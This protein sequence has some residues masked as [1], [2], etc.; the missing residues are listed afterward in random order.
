MKQRP[1]IVGITKVRNEEVIIQDTLD[2]FGQFCD[3][4]YVYDDLSDDDTFKIC[5][6][7]PKV[8]RTIKGLRWDQNRPKA[9]FQ[10]RQRVLEE[11]Q[12]TNP[13]W[14]LYFDADER[15]D[16]DFKEYNHYDAVIMKLFDF[17]ITP[18]DVGLP[19][20]ERKWLGP[21][22]RNILMMFRNAS[23]LRYE[24]LDQREI[25]LLPNAL[26]L[27]TGFV[28]HYGKA[29]SIDEWE[30]TCD[31]YGKY[32]PDYSQKWIDRK[33]KAVHTLSDFNRELIEWDEKSQK[34][35]PL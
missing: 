2:H 30:K 7:H 28:K 32:Y 33:G 31:Y 1:H 18:E 16:W 34:G 22:Y 6:S 5:N 25:M 29:I 35:V 21:E 26:R 23:V 10:T 20:Y 14:V 13:E 15:I 19:Y 8:V 3:A 9:E 12:T 17:Y 4:I 11:A 24:Y 27:N